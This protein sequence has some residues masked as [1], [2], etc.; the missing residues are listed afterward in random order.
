MQTVVLIF[1]LKGTN[2][3]ERNRVGLCRAKGAH[4]NAP[5]KQPEIPKPGVRERGF[6]WMRVQWQ[7]VAGLQVW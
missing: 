7:G 5:A 4:R 2:S 3:F 1:Q 6:S